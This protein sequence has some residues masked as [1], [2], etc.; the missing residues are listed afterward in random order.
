MLFFI[1]CDTPHSVTWQHYTFNLQFCRK[2]AL[3]IGKASIFIQKKKEATLVI[4]MISCSDQLAK[5]T[6]WQSSL[7]TSSSTTMAALRLVPDN[8][9]E[10]AS[11]WRR[12]WLV[13]GNEQDCYSGEGEAASKRAAAIDAAPCHHR[14]G[15]SGSLYT[16]WVVGGLLTPA[17][18][19]RR[20]KQRASKKGSFV[21]N[22]NTFSWL[23]DP[24]IPNITS[25]SG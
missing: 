4:C 13:V 2:N 3:D 5:N 12:R 10:A 22:V 23:F 6:S 7:Q 21:N 11:E 19:V 9:N 14:G 24:S 20:T 17:M 25:C 18:L 16:Q 15:S 1:T 8:T